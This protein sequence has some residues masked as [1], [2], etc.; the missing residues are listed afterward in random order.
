MG[1]VNY[2]NPVDSM[3]LSDQKEFRL[4]ALA[5]GLARAAYKKLGSVGDNLT[6][7]NEAYRAITQ[8]EWPK[9]LDCR[10]FQPTLDAA[11]A[12]DQWNTP[13]LAAIATAVSVFGTAAAPVLGANKIAVFYKVGIE[14]APMPVYRLIF[15]SGGATGNIIGVFDLEQLINQQTWVGYFSEPIVIDPTTTFSVQVLPRI[16][17]AVLARVQLGGLIF[18]PAGNVIAS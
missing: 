16:A 10:E 18:E 14:T 15:R 2:L 6:D 9:S 7:R 13:V 12:V 8:G 4:R 5:A 1:S 11:A 17:T 3:T